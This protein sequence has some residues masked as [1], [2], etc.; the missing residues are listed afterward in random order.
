MPRGTSKIT[1]PEQR[2]L[3]KKLAI[4]P[5]TAGL[6]LRAGYNDYG[7]LRDVTPNFIIHQLKALSNVPPEQA[8][9]L[10]RPLRRMVWLGT[11]EQP[12]MMAEKTA[13]PSYWTMKGLIAKG[14]WQEDFDDLTG[15]EINVRMRSA[16][17]P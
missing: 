15:D 6:L 5:K 17:L 14:V 12:E 11:Q 8:E 3:Q 10:R 2:E 13:H 16:G 7:Q 1:S 4:T 9:W